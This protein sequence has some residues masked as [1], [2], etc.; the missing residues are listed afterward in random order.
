[1][2]RSHKMANK[3]YMLKK[4]ELQIKFVL[5]GVKFLKIFRDN[6]WDK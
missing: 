6:H 3:L 1:M 4:Q 5:K 2:D